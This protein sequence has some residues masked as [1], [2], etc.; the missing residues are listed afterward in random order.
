MRRFNLLNL[1]TSYS[2]ALITGGLGNLQA[3]NLTI[4][5]QSPIITNT[6]PNQPT[7]VPSLLL[8]V[9]LHNL[10]EGHCCSARAGSPWCACQHCCTKTCDDACRGTWR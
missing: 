8:M 6:V 2:F 9:D 7:Q 1:R 4:V 10:K 5:A 3:L